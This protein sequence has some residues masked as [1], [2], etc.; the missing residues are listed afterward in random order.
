MK[1][2]NKLSFAITVALVLLGACGE[3]DDAQIDAPDE[4]EA[5]SVQLDEDD[6]FIEE[7][8]VDISHIHGLG[9]AGNEGIIYF[10]THEGL[11]LNDE[12]RWFTTSGELNDYMGFNAVSDGFYSSGHPGSDTKFEGKDPLGL[13]KSVDGGKNIYNLD[14]LEETD[15]HVKG[16]G[17]YSNAIY[18][19][20]PEPSS[21]MEETGLHYTL[22][23]GETWTKSEMNN[24]PQASYDHGN[25]PNY[26]IAVHPYEENVVA[27]GTSEGLYLSE[28]YG[29][30]F[31]AM[32]VDAP[33]ISMTYHEDHLY[34]AVWTG[35][36]ELLR[37]ADDG[38]YEVV[39]LP[40]MD[41]QDG[42]QYL[43][44]NP[45]NES[46]IVFTTFYGN[47]YITTDHGEFWAM[48]MEDFETLLPPFS[49]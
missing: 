43:A 3:N 8:N 48:I 45:Q 20:N 41:E 11:L 38:S 32:D 28:D 49:T 25:H 42:I 17:Y 21:R 18:V 44:V 37:L 13:V 36:M 19:Y 26:F 23:E 30:T 9:F 12:G 39:P 4:L 24:L 22:N 5:A 27:V 1:N 35:K 47:G 31:E 15:F 2:I 46:E 10:A 7:E 16:A 6:F 29:D 33:V 34:A 40:E 14:L